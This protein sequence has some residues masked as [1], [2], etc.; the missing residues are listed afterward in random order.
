MA[1]SLTLV[2]TEV[3]V[4]TAV[5]FAGLG[6]MIQRLIHSVDELRQKTGAQETVTAAHEL[7]LTAVELVTHELAR[8][9]P[10]VSE[11][12]AVLAQVVEKHEGWHERHDPTQHGR[13]DT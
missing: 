9:M 6:W 12:L 13:A 4:V 11:N 1:G 3:P 2:A 5:A 10:Q 8:K 7:R